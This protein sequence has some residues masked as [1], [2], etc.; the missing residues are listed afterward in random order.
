MFHQVHIQASHPLTQ[1]KLTQHCAYESRR[2]ATLLIH[3]STLHNTMHKPNALSDKHRNKKQINEFNNPST[4]N[5]T[6][7]PVAKQEISK[8]KQVMHANAALPETMFS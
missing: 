5:Y 2:Q 6:Q 8:T 4:H 7:L 1:R 3:T